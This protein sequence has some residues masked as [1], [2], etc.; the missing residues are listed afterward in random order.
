MHSS[1]RAD[2]TWA[3]RSTT[4]DAV[5]L[6][7]RIADDRQRVRD[8]PVSDDHAFKFADVNLDELGDQLVRSGTPTDSS[9]VYQRWTA[10]TLSPV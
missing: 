7:A 3:V 6:G 2:V 8:P 1:V 5:E 9:S 4:E 10:V